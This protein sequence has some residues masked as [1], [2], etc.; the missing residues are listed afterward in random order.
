MPDAVFRTAAA[1]SELQPLLADLGRRTLFTSAKAKWLLDW[2]PRSAG[3]A[4]I[5]TGSSMLAKI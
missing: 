2:R 4:V 3:E 1:N 5:A